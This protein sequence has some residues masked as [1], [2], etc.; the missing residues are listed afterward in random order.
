MI[1]FI[2]EDSHFGPHVEQISTDFNKLRENF[3]DEVI[4]TTDYMNVDDTLYNIIDYSN[5]PY[6]PYDGTEITNCYLYRDKFYECDEDLPEE[7]DPNEY[8]CTYYR[9]YTKG[10]LTSTWHK[11]GWE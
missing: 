11:D 5:M 6:K 4:Y 10:L 1:Y 7:L 2:I 8:M 3:P 9:T